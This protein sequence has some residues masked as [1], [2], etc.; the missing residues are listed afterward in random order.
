M[1]GLLLNRQH[2][3]KFLRS[4][5]STRE[6]IV[7]GMFKAAAS[8][9]HHMLI[10]QPLR[11]VYITA[12]GSRGIERAE[13]RCVSIFCCGISDVV[14]SGDAALSRGAAAIDGRFEPTTFARRGGR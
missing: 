1:G 5:P 11:S 12:S 9:F 14:T 10:M 13:W 2:V 3:Y 6:G 4:R 8:R 7:S